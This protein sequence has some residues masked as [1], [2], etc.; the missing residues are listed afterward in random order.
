[1]LDPTT[2]TL[3]LKGAQLGHG[4]AKSQAIK[5]R[6]SAIENTLAQLR[7]QSDQLITRELLSAYEAIEDASKSTNED[8]IKKRLEY[9]EEKLLINTNLDPKLSTSG[10]PNSYWIT[11]AH[12]ALAFICFIR[13]DQN[14][15][16]SHLLKAFLYDSRQA[17]TSSLV[18]L[19]AQFFEPKCKDIL[20]SHSIEMEN[21]NVEMLQT[22]KKI[23]DNLIKHMPLLL[24]LSPIMAYP[25]IAGTLLF[26]TEEE[27]NGLLKI[28]KTIREGL[29]GKKDAKIVIEELVDDWIKKLRTNKIEQLNNNLQERLDHRCKEIAMEYLKL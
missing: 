20:N 18:D 2:A 23:K 19:Y 22:R 4:I 12:L 8:T 11:Q 3:L 13:N 15:A 25:L 1:M 29:I 9:A 5:N 27:R 17:R 24:M 14:I 28:I 26:G 16:A 10:Y 21:L 7:K 6:L